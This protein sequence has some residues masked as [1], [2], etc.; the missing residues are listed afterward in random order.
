MMTTPKVS[1]S[2]AMEKMRL[3]QRVTSPSVA[4]SSGTTQMR[5]TQQNLQQ[6]KSNIGSLHEVDIF[7][8]CCKTMQPSQYAQLMPVLTMGGSAADPSSDGQEKMRVQAY[9]LFTRTWSAY[10]RQIMKDVVV[11]SKAVLCPVFGIYAQAKTLRQGDDGDGQKLVYMP[12][13][14]LMNSEHFAYEAKPPANLAY[15]TN[16]V[17]KSNRL[18]KEGT[19]ER[20]N[21]AAIAKAAEIPEQT[22]IY[23]LKQIVLA[24]ES[25][26]EQGY[27]I[28]L[29]LRIGQLRF[30]NGKFNF[31]QSDTIDAFSST[32][33]CN[34][35]YRI[36]KRYLTTLKDR[37]VSQFNDRDSIYSTV[38]DALSVVSPGN[39]PRS[40]LAG[41]DTVT[42]SIFSNS[43]K[44]GYHA[45]NPNPQNNSRCR[46]NRPS[47][48]EQ[49]LQT[50]IATGLPGIGS[51][52]NPSQN[53]G[54]RVVFPNDVTTR[55]DIQGEIDATRD[56]VYAQLLAKKEQR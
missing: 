31:I 44:S 3:P 27:T 7:K 53:Q 43:T 49:T 14:I 40:K 47:M 12:S 32:T 8:I 37:P 10:C 21:M 36:N 35:E 25:T 28:K 38:K 26:I 54:R 48:A 20:I 33:S 4:S 56:A 15:T 23:I 13:H 46:Y 1:L 9:K 24:V 19:L 16:E 5:L 18:F 42:A 55:R 11:N 39:R 41:H 17:L 2:K 52:H 30:S 29:N 51:P 6:L 22:I 34:T 50:G 45:A